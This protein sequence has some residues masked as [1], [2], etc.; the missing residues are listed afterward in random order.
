MQFQTLVPCIWQGLTVQSLPMNMTNIG[1]YRI[2]ILY[3][4]IFKG[5][6]LMHGGNSMSNVHLCTILCIVV[7]LIWCLIL[8]HNE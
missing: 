7:A 1:R 5:L 6:G 8:L 3:I 2:I 4:K